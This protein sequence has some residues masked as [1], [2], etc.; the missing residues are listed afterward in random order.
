MNKSTLI[1]LLST[2]SLFSCKSDYELTGERPDVN[3]G[4]VTECSFTAISD[5]VISSYDCNPVFRN[6]NENWGGDVG[7]VGFYA[8][9]VLGHAFYQMWYTSSGSDNFGN[10][11]MG[12]AVSSDGTN[13][14]THSNNPLFSAE[15]TAWDKDSVAGQVVV[16]DPIEQEYV[17]AY[18]GF[19]LGTGELDWN[20]F[21]IDSGIWGVGI[22]TSPDGINWTKSSRNPVINFTED[23][24]ALS[25][26]A[27]TP[28]WP[29]TITLNRRGFRGYIAANKAE[30]ALFGE[31]ACH[32]YAMD[33]VDAETWIINDQQPVFEAGS[34]YD[35][36]GFAS[37]SVVEFNNV[38]YMFYI[39]FT[40]WTQFDGYQSATDLTVNLAT[41]EDGGETWTR[42]PD[43]PLPISTS[44]TVSDVA[45]QVIGDRI[46]LWVTDDYDGEQAIGYYLFEPNIEPHEQ[47]GLDLSDISFF[48]LFRLEQKKSSL[49]KTLLNKPK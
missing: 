47:V 37:A 16:W 39:G 31:S 25:G 38:E 14:N 49:L 44:G 32:I 20:T 21:E 33:G 12:Y 18:Q 11:G 45:A 5:T 24:G 2:L 19:T 9:E 22:A 42:H 26:S 4:D 8:T 10:F 48:F 40:G 6:T 23:F 46:H 35:R 7:S 1:V 30:E 36:M 13:W 3:P 34:E 28:C 43:N 17:M 41:S 29:L 27:I 15:P